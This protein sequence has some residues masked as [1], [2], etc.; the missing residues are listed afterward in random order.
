M[1]AKLISTGETVDILEYGSDGSYTIYKNSTGKKYDTNFNFYEDFIEIREI[2]WEERRY[3]I[4]KE[5]LP[6][7]IVLRSKGFTED[8]VKA[9]LVYSDELIKQLKGE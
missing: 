2:D 1:K 7:L 5:V 8:P 3:Q 6:I 4:A 9:S